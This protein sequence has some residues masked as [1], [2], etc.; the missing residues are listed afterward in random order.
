MK[1]QNADMEFVAFDAQDVL[2][3]S[4]G[5]TMKA[6]GG[7]IKE[8]NNTYATGVNSAYQLFD[9]NGSDVEWDQTEPWFMFGAG[10]S[11]T[12]GLY[13]ADERYEKFGDTPQTDVHAGTAD[14][15]KGWLEQCGVVF[16]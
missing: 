14:D 8:Y 15:I 5:S 4:T 9:M 2:T 16:Q 3:S 6:P 12:N 10:T 1:I 11:D 7:V 13:Y